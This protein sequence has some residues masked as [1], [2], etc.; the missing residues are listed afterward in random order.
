MEELDE[1]EA[2]EAAGQKL[3]QEPTPPS[4]KR[5]H[6]GGNHA[7]G[8]PASATRKATPGATESEPTAQDGSTG[9]GSA[10]VESLLVEI[11]DRLDLLLQS[12]DHGQDGSGD[13]SPEGQKPEP[14]TSKPAASPPISEESDEFRKAFPHDE[15]DAVAPPTA[16]PVMTAPAP[17]ID[18]AQLLSAVEDQVTRH[19]LTH[20]SSVVVLLGWAMALLSAG[21]GMGYG[22]ITASGRY[23]F[24]WPAAKAG[25]LSKIAAAWLGAP[26]GVVLLPI[27]GAILWTASKDTDSEK[28]QT[29][30]RLAAILAFLAGILF[31]V[32]VLF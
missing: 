21:I 14:V 25:A 24:W 31:P 16:P 12:Q 7:G 32:V 11:R 8:R 17:I 27:A 18:T 15:A 6:A 20:H 13:A 5:G 30:L 28:H 9:E 3:M 2:L 23:P 22:Y 26:V 10:N 29:I 4:R 1:I 19:A